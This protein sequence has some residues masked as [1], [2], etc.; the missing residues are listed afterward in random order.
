M[1]IKYLTDLNL[2]QNELQNA[3]AHPLSVA[4]SA[5]VEGQFYVNTTDHKFYVYLNGAWKTFDDASDVANAIQAVQNDLNGY[6]ASN[7]A[8][9]ALKADDDA[10]VHLADTETITGVKTFSAGLKSD[11]AIAA[12]S[13]DTTVPTTAWVKSTIS[14]AEN[15]IVH[16][17]G[18]ESIAGTKT[19]TGAIAATDATVTVATQTP[20]D[21]SNN[22]ASTA[23]VDAAAG[24]VNGALEAY[25]TANDAAVA[26]KAADAAVV[27]NTGDETIEGTKTFNA[28]PVVPTVD[29]NDKSTKAASTAFVANELADYTYDKATIDQKID[30]KD[31][32][33]DQ[34]G[35]AGKWLT[36]D[37]TDSAWAS[38][39]IATESTL[40]VVKQGANITIDAEGTISS[41]IASVAGK[42]GVV[43][44]D[45][46]DVGLD[47]VDNTSDADKPVSTAQQAALDLKANA[48][49]VYTKA[50]T[51]NKTEIDGLMSSGLHYRGSVATYAELPASGQAEGDMYNIVAADPTHDVK[52]GDN[53]IWVA[54][55]EGVEAH[56]DVVSGVVDLSAYITATEIA[57]TYVN[58]TDY[59]SDKADL[60]SSIAGA[61]AAG[62]G[63][64]HVV[65]FSNPELTPSEGVVTWQIT[66]TAGANVL[67]QIKEASTGECVEM[68]VIQ[69]NNSLT[70]TFN[71][72]STVTAGTYVCVVT[73]NGAVN[74]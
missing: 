2:L 8:A 21:N 23:Y 72:A 29:L 30:E 62:T 40:G 55:H 47:N 28:S 4:P 67:A 11:E 15:G 44:L 57:D 69:A 33:P 18:D 17:T 53:V 63:A 39:P 71:A 14:T 73:G 61:L 7:D 49:D 36:T 10:V 27:H 46:T 20:G 1:A 51:Y 35:N 13:N 66:H 68:K 25:K 58:K 34:T 22:A 6:K 52:A 54:E 64:A 45:K 24:V 70:I 16:T 3:V 56:W 74:A 38:L 65:A 42:T 59:A 26:L 32:L 60:E 48:A 31:S 41:P 19:F 5:P 50:E 37:G 12:E 9:V 43:T